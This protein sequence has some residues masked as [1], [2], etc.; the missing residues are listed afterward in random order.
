MPAFL[1]L[2][3]IKGEA[4]DQDHKDW[5]RMDSMSHPITRS[6]PQ[7]AKDQQ[8]SKGETTLGDIVIVRQLDKSS[9]KLSEACASGKF[10]D[11]A[12]IDLC[13]T[14]KGKQ[15]P[16]LTYALK[17]VIV[18][19]YSFHGNGSGDPLPSEEV[20]LGFT[21]I[22]WTYIILDPNTGDSKGNVPGK[23]EPATGK[24]G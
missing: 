13:S 3:D 24:A 20:T 18:S 6:I 14:I 10:F 16:Y 4:T 1:K 8:R 5:I 2:G 19:S 21:A 12:Q 9:T 7:G 11:A 15:Q 17:N 22:E 23:Y